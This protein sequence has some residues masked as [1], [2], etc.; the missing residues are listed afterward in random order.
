MGTDGKDAGIKYITITSKHHDGFAMFDSKVSDY[1]IVKKTPYA[2]DVL[3]MLADECRKQGIKQDET[4]TIPKFGKKVVSA[5]LFQD[6]APVKFAENDFGFSLMVPKAKM[7]E[8][9]TIIELEVK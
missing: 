2:K 9:D 7:N 6:K 4:L 8:V 3:K 1:N 5:K